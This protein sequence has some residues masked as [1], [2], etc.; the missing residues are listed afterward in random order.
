MGRSL[1][2]TGIDGLDPAHV[3]HAYRNAA[4]LQLLGSL[5]GAVHHAADRKEAHIDGAFGHTMD[6]ARALVGRLDVLGERH[7]LRLAARETHGNGACGVDGKTQRTCQLR[8]V[9]GS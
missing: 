8:L 2:G 1:H 9:G 5:D 3:E 6:N 7:A 4:R